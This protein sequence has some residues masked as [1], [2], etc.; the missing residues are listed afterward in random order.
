MW[1]YRLQRICW[2]TYSSK[3]RNLFVRGVFDSGLEVW[4]PIPFNNGMTLAPWLSLTAMD[5]Q[6]LAKHWRMHC[7]I[8]L[9]SG[10]RRWCENS[11]INDFPYRTGRSERVNDYGSSVACEAQLIRLRGET[12]FAHHWMPSNSNPWAMVTI[13]HGFGDHGG[14]FVGMGTSLAAMGLSVVAVDLVG[15]GRSP[16][17]RGCI[18]SYDQLLDEVEA[19]VEYTC[20]HHGRIP[21]FLFGQ[22]MGGNLVLNLALRR[23]DFC[24]S[25]YGII[26]GSPMLRASVMPKDRV[27]EAGRWLAKHIPNWRIKAP[28][29]VSKL[30][31]DRRAQDAY[32]RDRYV[33]R[34]MSLR[35][36]ASLIDSGQ[37][38]L[39]NASQLRIPT[40]ITH[41]ADDTLTCP[42]ASQD[43]VSTAGNIAKIKL[44][45]GCRHDLHDDLQ[46]ERFFA[47]LND[48][49]KRQ[50]VVTYRLPVASRIAA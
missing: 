28:V 29:Q 24:H 3:V 8:H 39:E 9:Q 1:V 32:L 23:P 41:G 42:I 31:Q 48:W 36:A 11:R 26:A 38:A 49:M 34:A 10:K 15:H 20:E 35:L 47:Y 4:R 16:G 6:S 33:H 21:H 25:L 12:R 18:H 7:E 50:C 19:S 5:W 46:R 14:R 2:F 37:W 43:F 30:S 27:M 22:S 13:V 40:L 45:A 17:R 44:W